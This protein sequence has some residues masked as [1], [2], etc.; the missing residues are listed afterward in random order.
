MR[1]IKN[2]VPIF[3]GV[4]FA[5]SLQAQEVAP[6]VLFDYDIRVSHLKTQEQVDAVLDEVS[7]LAGVSEL[8]FILTDYTLEF[9]CTNH[10][11]S[12]H[13]IIDRIKAIL[14]KNGIEIVLVER[15]KIE[16]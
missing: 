14:L 7:A 8:Q 16:S 12:K 6:E 13:L 5:T 1:L 9:Q 2:F 10:D 11:I 4:V 15:V 3:A